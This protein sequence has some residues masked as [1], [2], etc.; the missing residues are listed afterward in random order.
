MDGVYG[1]WKGAGLS[2]LLDIL[3]TVFSSG[4][5]THEISKRKSEYELSQTFIAIDLEQLKNYQVSDYKQSVPV[6]GKEVLYPGERVLES[7]EK[8]EGRNSCFEKSV[9]RSRRLFMTFQ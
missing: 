4:L 2:L 6:N 5:S 8:F 9:R 3:S 1:Y 7:S